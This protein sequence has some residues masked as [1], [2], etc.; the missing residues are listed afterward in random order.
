MSAWTKRR[1]RQEG[2]P[3]PETVPCRW[4]DACEASWG[5]GRR[6][7]PLNAVDTAWLRM[8]EP[9]NA[10]DVV[11]VLIFDG[12]FPHERLREILETRLL[13]HRRFRE[14]IRDAPLG[15]AR[16]RFEPEPDF[17]LDAHLHRDTL[18]LHGDHA[19]LEK[20]VSEWMNRPLDFRR[21]PWRI[22]RVDRH[23]RGTALIAQIHHCMGDG[24]A[25]MEVLLSLSDERQ[26]EPVCHARMS[27]S[28]RWIRHTNI[29]HAP[30]VARD[31]ALGF[32]EL[33]GLSFDTKSALRGSL[34]GV[35]RAAWSSPISL[36]RIKALAHAHR[37]TI[38]DLVMAIVSGALR[39]YLAA[40]GDPVDRLALR[41]IVPVNLRPSNVPIDLEHG[42]WFG[43]VFVEMP[44][45]TPSADQRLAAIHETTERIKRSQLPMV[46]LAILNLVGRVPTALGRILDLV[47]A[48]KSSLVM[49]NVKGPEERL[50][51]SGVPLREI[52]FWVPHPARLALGISI[53][54]YSG[55][56]RIGVR[57][58]VHAI[59]DPE[60]II[61]LFEEELLSFEQY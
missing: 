38:N 43:L 51:L 34:S 42:N 60:R 47:F 20:L 14:R 40:R 35:R 3:H 52:V 10:V 8:E 31:A 36:A 2:T 55:E 29:R 27:F 49:T 28:A 23:H 48:R 58:D 18:A 30:R 59:H 11:G 13:A 33:L 26:A 15:I 45:C 17:S 4:H 61:A 6:S 19:E 50:H 12:H 7:R 46:S 54:S 53:L 5:M 9:E 37:C 39:Q 44:V 32:F 57:S 22:I 56:V 21:S 1:G 25:L 16:P 41:A 24:F